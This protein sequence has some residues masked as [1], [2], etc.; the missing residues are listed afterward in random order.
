M[1]CVITQVGI[2]CIKHHFG[3][4][5]ISSPHHPPPINK[6]GLER[7]PAFVI[8]CSACSFGDGSLQLCNAAEVE[9]GH[10][11]DDYLCTRVHAISHD[12]TQVLQLA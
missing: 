1:R 11:P 9:R 5:I 2:T 10:H 4:S 7:V 6:V 8:I 12:G 3:R